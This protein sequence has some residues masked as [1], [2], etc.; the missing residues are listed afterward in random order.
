MDKKGKGPKNIEC[1]EPE[2]VKLN[3]ESSARL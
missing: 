3:L 2:Y 1:P